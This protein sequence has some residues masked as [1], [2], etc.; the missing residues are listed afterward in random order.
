MS[1]RSPHFRN[2]GSVVL[3]HGTPRSKL[4]EILKTGL[5]PSPGWVTGAE[6]VYLSKTRDGALYWA[7]LAFMAAREETL[8]IARFDR[9]YGKD[10]EKLLAIVSVT[11]PESGLVHLRADMEQAEDVGFEGEAGDWTASL[12]EIGDAMFVERVP[13]AWISE[14]ELP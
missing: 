13:A 4:K 9:R 1:N 12:D 5:E 10:V 14:V 11:I 3:F 8:E 7:K 6:G 2:T